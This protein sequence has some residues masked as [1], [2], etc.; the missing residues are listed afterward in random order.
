MWLACRT[1]GLKLFDSIAGLCRWIYVDSKLC[2]VWFLSTEMVH[3]SWQTQFQ[4]NLTDAGDNPAAPLH[5]SNATGDF[6]L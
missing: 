4:G 2:S 6:M 1:F 3:F 5:S